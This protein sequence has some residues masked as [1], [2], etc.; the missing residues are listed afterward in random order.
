MSTKTTPEEDDDFFGSAHI[1]LPDTVETTGYTAEP[2]KEVP[3]IVRLVEGLS[4][5]NNWNKQKDALGRLKTVFN[6]QVP[7]HSYDYY[8]SVLAKHMINLNHKIS[9]RAGPVK[10]LDIKTDV[11][12]LQQSGTHYTK[13][14]APKS[15]DEYMSILGV[16]SQIFVNDTTAH[17]AC[18]F[19]T[20][21]D[22]DDKLLR[23]SI[24]SEVVLEGDLWSPESPAK[25]I[26]AVIPA[27]VFLNEK[28][29]IL[30]VCEDSRRRIGNTIS[31]YASKSIHID[32]EQ[33]IQDV[34]ILNKRE[35]KIQYTN[36]FVGV[37]KN[38]RL[39]GMILAF[40]DV[41]RSLGYT[42]F[43]SGSTNDHPVAIPTWLFA[44]ICHASRLYYQTSTLSFDATNKLEFKIHPVG[45]EPGKPGQFSATLLV[46]YVTYPKNK[47]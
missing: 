33:F 29:S 41:L 43:L 35:E 27:G 9:G 15:D 20:N 8:V 36:L 30:T 40:Q 24:C 39:L 45:V 7:L 10:N 16:T 44:C 34:D 21:K 18:S 2:Q 11:V 26:T 42:Q 14:L 6:N 46:H 32:L 4:N 19:S 22:L 1:V 13:A 3:V 38:T 28:Q 31:N 17:L 12:L 37:R 23:E 47:Y 5:D 25:L